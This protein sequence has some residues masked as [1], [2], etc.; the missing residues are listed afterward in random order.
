MKAEALARLAQ[1]VVAT[2]PD[3]AKELTARAENVAQ[4]TNNYN[5][6]SGLARIARA[7]AATDPKRA[8]ELADRAERATRSIADEDEMAFALLDLAQAA[9]A[10]ILTGRYP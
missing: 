6:A 7:I 3:R 1:T 8:E 4:S 9:A 5:R 2:D 10:I